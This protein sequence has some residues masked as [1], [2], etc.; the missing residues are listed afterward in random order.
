[1]EPSS[2]EFILTSDFLFLFPILSGIQCVKASNIHVSPNT[3]YI[4]ERAVMALGVARRIICIS[5]T[6]GI[7]RLSHVLKHQNLG[8]KTSFKKTSTTMLVPDYGNETAHD[9]SSDR[10]EASVTELL[11]GKQRLGWEMSQDHIDKSPVN[12]QRTPRTDYLYTITVLTGNRWAADTEA[13]LYITLVGAGGVESERLWLRQE[14]TNWLQSGANGQRFRQNHSDSFQFRVPSR[15]GILKKLTIG[16]DCKGYGAG[17]FIDRIMVTEDEEAS[18][19]CRQFLFLCNKWLDSGQVDGKLE[20]TIRLSSF[21]EISSI[22]I[23]DRVTRGRWELILHGGSEKGLGGTTSQLSITGYGTRAQSTTSGLYDSNMAKVPSDALIQ[24]DFGDIGELLKVRV[25]ID[26][27][28]SSPDYFLN[29]V[30]FKD[31]D[32][33]ERF[34]VMCGKWLRWKST[35]KGDQPFR[36]LSAFHIG[37]EPLPLITYEGKISVQS[38]PKIEC[39]DN[40]EVLMDLHGDLGETGIFRVTIAPQ[41]DYKEKQLRSGDEENMPVNEDIGKEN[42]NIDVSFKV[43][44]VSVGRVVGARLRFEPNSIGEQILDGLLAIQ[45]LFQKQG[46]WPLSTNSEFLC[47]RILLRESYHTPYRYVLT[48]SQFHEL[49]EQTQFCTKE[50]LTTEM[51]GV[52]TRLPR[53]KQAPKERS[54]WLLQV[55]LAYGSSILPEIELCGE[56]GSNVRMRPMDTNCSD[57]MLSYQVPPKSSQE[58][59]E[60]NDELFGHHR[61]S[62]EN[63]DLLGKHRERE[64]NDELFE[65]HRRTE[66]DAELFGQLRKREEN[67]ELF[68]HHRKSEDVAELFGQLRKIR[69]FIEDEGKKLTGVEHSEEENNLEDKEVKQPFTIVEKIRISDTVNGDEIRFPA[70]DCHLQKYSVYELSAI[71]PDKPPIPIVIYFV[72]IVAGEA[73]PQNLPGINVRLNITG[74]YGDVGWRTLSNSEIDEP[75]E[76]QQQSS[77]N[78]QKIQLFAPNTRNSF[79][80]EAVSIG[81]LD[82]AE[83]EVFCSDVQNFSW[84]CSEL[85]IT[86][87]NTA[88][89]YKFKFDSPFSETCRLQRCQTLPFNEATK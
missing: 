83:M 10:E 13:D 45:G 62:E 57:G 54:N 32:T 34:V 39:L 38:T 35:K 60:E 4:L 65:H 73:S 9:S 29:F 20:R 88:L 77:E 76:Q 42:E 30:E 81:H 25:E 80:F 40:K 78:Q 24:L 85:I 48:R 37:V 86:D 17:I 26:G 56:N 79:E 50:L 59:S 27:T 11:Q 2:S 84:E 71:W 28:G 19:D 3:Q 89:Y 23:E 44:A 22:P 75:S 5:P 49:S 8:R 53:R 67:D 70:A 18:D 87:T 63:A 55:S 15:L 52:S 14:F 74:E 72:R 82:F 12:T 21:Y 43:E 41:I 6:K 58:R 61:K 1:M 64:E 68:G 46:L 47:G 33:E 16:H 51:E 69:I 36:E 66:E 31:L 7:R